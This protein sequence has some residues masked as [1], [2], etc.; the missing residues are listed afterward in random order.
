M[1]EKMKTKKAFTQ[2]ISVII[3]MLCMIC[4][5]NMGFALSAA[6]EESTGYESTDSACVPDDY[7]PIESTNEIAPFSLKGSAVTT[8]TKR[9][10]LIED[11][12]PWSSNANSTVLSSLG[13]SYD[14]VKASDF[15]SQ[16]LG[17]YSV[18][19]FANDQQFSTYANYSNFM[20][21]VENFAALGGVV[22]F[23]ACD[24]G[25]ANG[26]MTTSLPGGISKIHQYANYNYIVDYT[27]PIVTGELID[28]VALV[29][30]DLYSNYCSHTSFDEASLPNGGRIIL[31]DKIQNAPTLVEYKLGNG[32]VIA[33]GL[34]WEYAYTR[35]NYSKKAMADLFMYAIKI[36][37]ANVDMAPPLAVSVTSPSK[38]KVVEN[39][40]GN[41]EYSPNPFTITANIQNIGNGVAYNVNAELVLPDGMK[42]VSGVPKVSLGDIDVGANY[43][44]VTWSVEVEPSDIDK[45]ENYSMIITADNADTK[46]VEKQIEIPAIES[47]EKIA[48][49]LERSAIDEGIS[50][51]ITLNFKLVNEGTE[52]LQ[53]GQYKVRYYYIDE[54]PNIKKNV[55]FYY[56]GVKGENLIVNGECHTRITPTKTLANSYI[57]FS[58]M[59]TKQ[60]EP[61]EEAFIQAYITSVKNVNMKA[62]NDFS[63]VNSLYNG[64]SGYV[65]WNKIPIYKNEKLV[66]GEEPVDSSEPFEP[67]LELV[68]TI[69]QD[70]SSTNINLVLT[71]NGLTPFVLSE[72]EI[73]YHFTNDDRYEDIVD[74]Y[75]VGG[76]FDGEYYKEIKSDTIATISKLKYK[77]EKANSCLSIKF[78]PF[79]GTLYYGE[80]LK[81]EMKI[82]NENWIPGKNDLI[83]DFSYSKSENGLPN[84]LVNT[85]YINEF[86]EYVSYSYGNPVP[87][88]KPTF[89]VF[90]VGSGAEDKNTLQDYSNFIDGFTTRFN[91]IP[92]DAEHSFGE[93]IT[94]KLNFDEEN[95]ISILES[96]IAYIS[97][98]GSRG[99]VIPI[100]SD[101]RNGLSQYDKILTTD[102][103]VG[104][105]Y[106]DFLKFKTSD[107]KIQDNNIF[108]FNMKDHS[109]D[110]VCENLRWIICAACC[111][112]N[113]E[114]KFTTR[115][116]DDG[117]PIE[118]KTIKKTSVDRWINVLNNNENLRGILGYWHS[119]PTAGAGNP[120][121]AV[122]DN[123]L[124]YAEN[125]EDGG[126]EYNIHEAW[127]KA[128][129]YRHDVRNDTLPCGLLVKSGYDKDSLYNS[130]S[131]NVD[132]TSY[133]FIFLYTAKYVS[134]PLGH[135]EY[136]STIYGAVNK[137]SSHFG[138]S[139]EELMSLNPDIMQIDRDTYNYDGNEV[140]SEVNEIAI[141]V[142]IS[143][144]ALYDD[145]ILSETIIIYNLITDEVEIL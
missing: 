10:L 70:G 76:A 75:N 21:Q 44:Q 51:R 31:R 90:K 34:T 22:I 26:T 38:L 139:V 5:C 12:L 66:Y 105:D 60:I 83:N 113:T 108:S 40:L 104:Q 15:L 37:N 69:T 129:F 18:L 63:A 42:I 145:D 96:D 7:V 79:S 91:G 118:S 14:K 140:V 95:L 55:G 136:D 127:I 19:I 17:D 81:L 57:E 77:K 119:A 92:Y 67:E 101:F 100:Y 87:D 11:T 88:Y 116:N 39:E 124:K 64:E 36:S 122:I 80:S 117:N 137:V 103:F 89:S 107:D 84:I 9:V 82:H 102:A 43:A 71:N 53:L 72:S 115:F 126:A 2:F 85:N 123:F 132:G 6:A 73:L 25:W 141:S 35:S 62:S 98:H 74:V 16:D 121:Y 128:N 45:I 143:T 99:G 125:S 23:G 106:Q 94:S 20:T 27:H 41:E 30:A 54:A 78:S 109:S 4:N 46:T 24:A 1:E 93:N 142:P 59:T 120:D 32:T 131:E 97:G 110:T 111:Q 112:V 133:D 135:I 68:P 49:Y 3:S 8:S 134:P 29:D 114:L 48:L 13:V 61:D 47:T 58:F 130:L 28:N 56:C 50:N 138:I 52:S 65:K 33:S 144:Y 86:G